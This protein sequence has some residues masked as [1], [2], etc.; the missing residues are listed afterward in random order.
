MTLKVAIEKELRSLSLKLDFE[1]PTPGVAALFGPSGC[2]KSTTINIIAGL[3]APD[4]GE[5]ALEE[6]VLLDT[7]RRIDVAAERRRIGYVFQDARLFPHLNVAA[8]LAYAERRA[9]GPAYV[10]LERILGLLDLEP[11][12]GRR[13]SASGWPSHGRCSPG[14]VCCCW[15]SLSP[16]S[17][18]NGAKRSCRI[19][20]RC[21]MSCRFPWCT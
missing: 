12:L 2:G 16:P 17:T 6:R 8:N 15:M 3:L 10:T 11:L 5:I 20:R 9:V 18:G 7:Q 19:W 1:L 13:T 14:R 4:R 21:A